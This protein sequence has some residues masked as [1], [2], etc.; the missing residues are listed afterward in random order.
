MSSCVLLSDLILKGRG[1]GAPN[2]NIKTIGAARLIDLTVWSR[3]LVTRCW[4]ACL[5]DRCNAVH[6]IESNRRRDVAGCELE[7][8]A[9]ETRIDTWEWRWGWGRLADWRGTS[10]KSKLT[11]GEGASRNRAR[12]GL[13]S[14]YEVQNTGTLG[15]QGNNHS[16][17]MGC[18]PRDGTFASFSACAW[19][20]S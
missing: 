20:S 9:N 3:L 5:R 19:E 7:Y 1:C 18:K 2:L 8:E 4:F 13:V 11:P 17:L 16:N 15:T 6:V 14:S 12:G 10:V